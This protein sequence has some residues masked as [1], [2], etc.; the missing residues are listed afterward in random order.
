MFS[1]IYDLS[2][3]QQIWPFKVGGQSAK[4]EFKTI[5]WFACY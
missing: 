4:P 3:L 2:G 5:S 1:N